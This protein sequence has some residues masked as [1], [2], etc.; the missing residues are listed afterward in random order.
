MLQGLEKTQSGIGGGFNSTH[1]S[2]ASRLV[3][4]RIASNRYTRSPDTRQF[5][6]SRFE[7]AAR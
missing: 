1:P 4:A 5:R 2:P 6:E 3:N 7:E